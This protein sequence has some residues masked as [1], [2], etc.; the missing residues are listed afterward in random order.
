M[1]SA[2][3]LRRQQQRR[4]RQARQLHGHRPPPDAA[5]R[6]RRRR[7]GRSTAPAG[8]T[9]AAGH[10]PAGRA[11]ARCTANPTQP[12][13]HLAR[14]RYSQ[15]A[16]IGSP[17]PIRER[18]QGRG[19]PICCSFRQSPHTRAPQ[20]AATSRCSSRSPAASNTDT[21]APTAHPHPTHRWRPRGSFR[22]TH[23]AG[24]HQ[25]QQPVQPLKH[26]AANNRPN[27]GCD[28]A[29]T[30]T[31]HG[32]TARSCCSLSPS[33]PALFEAHLKKCRGC[34]NYLDQFRITARTVGKIA[35]DDLDPAFRDRLLEACVTGDKR[36]SA[37]TYDAHHPANRAR[38]RPRTVVQ[39]PWGVLVRFRSWPTSSGLNV[40]CRRRVG[41]RFS[42]VESS[43][44][45]A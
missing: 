40:L 11:T 7:P 18:D 21:R 8:S 31:S 6:G 14:R 41:D 17:L 43:G 39:S 28:S 36:C 42:F 4:R 2:D 3:L 24:Q 20:P 44:I 33:L 45:R 9:P 13:R 35:E 10:P 34:H 15:R 1:R 27:N 38:L 37:S 19:E 30:R 12:Q 16:Q 25:Q 32:N 5:D 29:T 26:R 22:A 23:P